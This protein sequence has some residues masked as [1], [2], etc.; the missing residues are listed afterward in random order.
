MLKNWQFYPLAIALI[1]GMIYIALSFGER[2]EVD[3]SQGYVLDGRGLETLVNSEGT[4]VDVT[5]DAV[6]PF[7]HA[8]LSAHLSLEE[9]PPSA[10]VFATLANEY[11]QAF[12]DKTIEITVQARSGKTNPTEDFK[13]AYFGMGAKSSGW[14]DFTA[15]SEFQDFS[16][17]HQT[18]AAS[19]E[20]TADF[21]GIWPDETGKKR[22]LE[23]KSIRVRIAK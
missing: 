7:D 18:K 1:A 22:T 23:I 21:L 11:K 19:E 3:P 12:A 13:I 5:G 14:K 2:Y 4:S 6:N 15:T 9:A 10:G 17:T 16:F 20:R 8:V